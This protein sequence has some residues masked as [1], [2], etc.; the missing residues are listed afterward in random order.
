MHLDLSCAAASLQK[1]L[2]ADFARI[3]A[4][5]AILR[6]SE[7]NKTVANRAR[8]AAALLTKQQLSPIE[9]LIDLPLMT[10]PELQAAM[11]VVSA[12]LIPAYFTDIHLFCLLV[13]RM[14]NVSMQHGTS[15]PSAHADGVLRHD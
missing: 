4:T 11:Q 10:D 14:V 12:L 3:A 8:P 2:I 9:S 7:H 5:C 15:G 13:C 1:D 6:R